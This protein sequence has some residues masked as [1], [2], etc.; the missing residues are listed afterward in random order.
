MAAQDFEN[1][2]RK[3]LRHWSRWARR[4]DVHA[5]RVYDRDLH[6]YAVA[7]DLYRTD[8]AG[9]HAHVQEYE[10]PRTVDPEKADR[11]LD[12][13]R[14]IVQAVA[15]ID[16]ERVHLK[17]RRRRKAGEQYEKLADTGRYHEVREGGHRFRV[18]FTDHLDTGLFLDHRA[19]RARVGTLAS[20]RRFLNLFC[21]TGTAT[22]YAAKGGA[23]STL[24]VDLSKTYLDWARANF[25]SN[26]LDPARHALV[27]AD[28]VDWL[29]DARDRFG[30]IFLD[31]PTFS[32]SKKMRGTFD[33]Q[34]D[35]VELLRNASRLL[36]ADGWLL[37]SNNLRTFELDADA[38]PELA[39]EEITRR[40]LPE[41]FARSPRIH[42]AWRIRRR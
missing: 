15:E 26:G 39:F 6:D 33:V 13:V 1:R 17:V 22:V 32:A 38:L 31:P 21:Y 4:N 40:T 37:F 7:I 20:G 36:D 12:E 42:H 8:D 19:T 25:A 14:R 29:R 5:F 27:R 35:H 11:R 10:P 24:S 9:T 28:V 3:N 41:D 18:N 34:R 2:L 23:V 16:P 30:L